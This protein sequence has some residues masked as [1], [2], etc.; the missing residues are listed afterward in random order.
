MKTSLKGIL[1]ILD[2]EA[3][4]LST[5]KDSK[6]V[7][8]IGVGHTAAAGG[9]APKPGNRITIEH[10][11]SLFASDLAKFERRVEKS[12]A[13]V[14]AVHQND[15]LVS[16]DFNTGAIEGGSV[17]EKIEANNFDAAMNALQQYK[18]S[19]GIVLPGLVKRRA[20]ERAMFERGEYPA[21]SHI[22]VYDRMPGKMRKVAV[23]S[24]DLSAFASGA[25]TPAG[26][27][28]PANKPRGLLAA[29]IDLFH[30]IFKRRT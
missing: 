3:L 10:A 4:V 13:H 25:Q 14:L 7:L 23:S 16:F 1:A 20:R 8:T 22:K 12:V 19:G 26:S 11:I 17:D 24:L 2:E 27:A 28:T 21:V 29:L 30:A 18:K 9:L 5:Y 6:G 15:A